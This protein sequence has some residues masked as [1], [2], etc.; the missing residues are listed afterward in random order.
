MSSNTPSPLQER[1]AQA[2]KV[3]RMTEDE[4]W[5]YLSTLG[6]DKDGEDSLSLIEAETTRA[7]DA[8]G[9][10][11]GVPA[12]RFHAGWAILKGKS[13]KEVSSANG[14]E[15]LIKSL[16]P[17]EQYSDQEL[18][19]EYGP[20]ASSRVVDELRRRSKDNPFVV[21]SDEAVDQEMTLKMLRLARRSLTHD[22][23]SYLD[24]EGKSKTY[25]LFRIGQF[26][27]VWIDESP[28]H[29][30]VILADGY[31][32][33]CQN[34]W[35]GIEEKDRIIVRVACDVGGVDVGSAAKI[36]ELISK[37]REK[38]SADFLL[39]VPVISARYE[40]LSENNRLPI[41]RRRATATGPD[42]KRD[43]LF[44]KHRTY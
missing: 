1:V 40:E 41:L 19:A 16:R 38:K 13:K 28:I 9:V 34:T 5:S 12:P 18:V 31:C 27:A 24:A 14:T 6:I 36:H 15:E 44:V 39:E 29:P 10:F 25:R 35:D 11:V 32:H 26:P 23:H 7:E 33:R 30:D 37:I 22:A 3:M 43:P 8:I 17:I 42:G 2:S 21:F 20:E 4:M